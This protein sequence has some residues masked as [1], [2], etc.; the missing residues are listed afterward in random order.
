MKLD[1]LT[2]MMKRS[3][4]HHIDGLEV[5]ARVYGVKVVPSAALRNTDTVM[6]VSQSAYD[7]LMERATPLDAPQEAE[8]E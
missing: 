8:N 2:D 4:V 3:F 5:A 7:A 1:E 6:M